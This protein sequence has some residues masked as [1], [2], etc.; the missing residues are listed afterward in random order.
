MAEIAQVVSD[1]LQN[2]IRQLLPSQ[3]GFGEDLQASNVIVPIVDLTQTAE[4]AGL[5]TD[6]QTAIA[7]GSQTAFSVTAATATIINTTGFYRIFGM[8]QLLASTGAVRAGS[9]S[10]TDGFSTKKIWE[11]SQLSA[12]TN[13]NEHV[14][15]D[16]IAFFAAG[17]SMTVTCTTNCAFI[18]S[19]RQIATVNGTLVNPSGF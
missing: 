2:K 5:S 12:G 11:L 19:T 6:L 9:F 8:A 1:T 3:R 15:F 14:Q 10:L 7:F 18:G 16:F 17:E 13:D 4:G